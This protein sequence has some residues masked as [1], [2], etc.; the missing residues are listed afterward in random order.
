[1]LTP[2]HEGGLVEEDVLG[3][4]ALGEFVARASADHDLL[5]GL[6][7]RLG[8]LELR[9]SRIG[10]CQNNWLVLDFEETL[11]RPCQWYGAFVEEFHESLE[12]DRSA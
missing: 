3:L 12:V 1:M 8:F 2:D 11:G 9:R 7:L 5:L 4:L 10:F 6:R